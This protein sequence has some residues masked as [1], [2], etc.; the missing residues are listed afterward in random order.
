MGPAGAGKT[1]RIADA[2]AGLIENG[3]R[4]DRVLC[5]V[6]QHSAIARMRRRLAAVR[7][8]TRGEPLIT[9]ISAFAQRN[10]S[11]F[12]PV[13][14]QKAG[15]ART[16]REPVFT[17]LES[18]QYFVNQHL[19]AHMPA[20]EGL[21]LHRPRIVS[22]I[23]DNMNRAATS[24]FGL[25]EIAARL[26]L[27]WP[28]DTTR[29]RAF[30]AVQ[31]T[32]LDFRAFCLQHTLLDF[33]LTMSLFGGSLLQDEGFASYARARFRHLL[34]DNVEEETPALHD[35]ARLLLPDC[36]SALIAED[37]PGGYRVFLGADVS[38]ARALRELCADGVEYLD[39][40]AAP[41]GIPSPARFGEQ[42]AAL[43]QGGAPLTQRGSD[44]VQVLPGVKYWT[45]MV[46]QAVE[47]V[48]M[49]VDA[50]LPPAEIAIVAPYVED[51]LR[52]E[53]DERLGASIGVRTLRPSRPLHDHPIVRALIVFAK[54]AHPG[55]RL[56]PAAGEIARALSIALGD[57]DVVRAQLLAEQ[58]TR[59]QRADPLPALDDVALWTRVGA[60]YAE[61]YETLRA[62]LADWMRQRD[63]DADGAPLDLF[64]QRLFSDVLSVNGFGLN[65]DRDGATVVA[66]LV[67]LARQFR[68]VFALGRLS[69][70]PA[71]LVDVRMYGDAAKQSA[72]AQDSL[73]LTY[74]ALLTEGML[75]ARGDLA[76]DREGGVLL[77]T[78][79]AYITNDM[80][81]R[82][83]IWLDAQA[84]AWH[85]RI[86][87]PLTHPFV[88][89]R[90][91]P[92][93][94]VWTDMDELQTTRAS[95]ARQVC[96]LA[97]RCSERIYMLSSQLSVSGQ[98]ENGLLLRAVQR[99]L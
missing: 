35:L 79:H 27:A 95:L 57:L 12:F 49:L 64:W 91:W 47:I 67:R 52:F 31:Q 63:A 42:L 90:G 14:A 21:K 1:T 16:D 50:G 7:T 70:A 22:Q 2:L 89:M 94:Q 56:Q 34:I 5:L 30:E 10:V 39:R 3:V 19:E 29:N 36:E 4:P 97:Y 65:A 84:N 99:M 8:P 59:I 15:F 62:W 88:M 87:Q 38:S 60:R 43:V 66:R 73:G 54:L 85:E 40:P 77:A 68:E 55:W 83:Q 20:F 92:A 25:D 72:E 33:S 78:A 86:Y 81:S 26:R 6:A 28:G 82:V 71:R 18:A 80:R 48:R 51:V 96:G 53:L 9:T 32:A 11:L 45:S 23:I 76:P 46:Q 69:T 98:E 17:T 93:A 44:A 24:G 75:A 37:D 13:L 41:D 74:I 61:R 58:I